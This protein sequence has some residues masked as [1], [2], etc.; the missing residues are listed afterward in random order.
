MH[1]QRAADFTLA[2]V[3]ETLVRQGALSDEAR[4]TACAREGIQRTRLLRDQAARSGGRG[5]RRAELSP[6]ELLASFER[7]KGGQ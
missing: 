1:R 2:F 5:L 7:L 3:A 4:R 6:V